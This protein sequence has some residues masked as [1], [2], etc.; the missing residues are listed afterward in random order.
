MRSAPSRAP[1]PT[2]AGRRPWPRTRPTP[3]LGARL[4][5]LPRDVWLAG[6]GGVLLGSVA[7]ATAYW[8]YLHVGGPTGAGIA[9]IPVSLVVVAVAYGLLARRHRR[10]SDW[11][12][13]GYTAAVVVVTGMLMLWEVL[14]GFY[15]E[16]SFAAW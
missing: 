4:F 14:R 13:L 5:G 7:A 10:A 12:G 6:C 16:L 2:A 11:L 8:M 3:R 15:A 9:V 1:T